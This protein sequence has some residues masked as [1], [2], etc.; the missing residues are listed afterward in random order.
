MACTVLQIPGNKAEGFCTWQS[1]STL[2]LSP[3]VCLC[4]PV[5]EGRVL[6]P[7]GGQAEGLCTGLAKGPAQTGQFEAD[8]G[9]FRGKDKAG[10][11][12][13]RLNGLLGP[14]SV[15]YNMALQPGS[16]GCCIWHSAMGKL[17]QGIGP[18]RVLRS[19]GRKGRRGET[20]KTGHKA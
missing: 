18:N 3:S 17:R 2:R 10:K 12:S 8:P 5:R 14:W 13:L 6:G 4:L 7:L 11:Q 19:C 16:K 1:E 20:G 15:H 9:E